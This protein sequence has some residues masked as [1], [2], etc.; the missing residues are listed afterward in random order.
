MNCTNR[1][2]ARASDEQADLVEIEAKLEIARDAVTRARER[3]E[4][5][6]MEDG[7]VSGRLEMFQEREACSLALHEFFTGVVCWTGLL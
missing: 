1:M 3:V 5:A 2:I 6:T 4:D 7:T